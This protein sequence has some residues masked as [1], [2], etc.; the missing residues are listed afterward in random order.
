MH[1]FGGILIFFEF[2]TIFL[3]GRVKK[4]IIPLALVGFEIITV[5]SSQRKSSPPAIVA[6][7]K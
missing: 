2:S 4:T 1:N 7:A 5:Y 6:S 3:G